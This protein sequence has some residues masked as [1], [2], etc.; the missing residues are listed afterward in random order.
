MIEKP[1]YII[2]HYRNLITFYSFGFIIPKQILLNFFKY[3]SLEKFYQYE[4]MMTY[5]FPNK[6]ESDMSI[7]ELRDFERNNIA[8]IK[9]DLKENKQNSNF[10]DIKKFI[11]VSIIHKVYL[12]SNDLIENILK[13]EFSNVI[14]MNKN[15]FE[16]N[17]SYSTSQSE[18][19]SNGKNKN[20]ISET[21]SDKTN[22]LDKDGVTKKQ[23]INFANFQNNICI[24]LVLIDFVIKNNL[25]E[26][27]FDKRLPASF[28]SYSRCDK[29]LKTFSAS[30]KVFSNDLDAQKLDLKNI[31]SISNSL[32]DDVKPKEV[33]VWASL[34]KVLF[35]MVPEFRVEEEEERYIDNKR[36]YN[37]NKQ[38][39]IDCGRYYKKL[40]EEFIEKEKRNYIEYYKDDSQKFISNID[41]DIFLKILGLIVTNYEDIDFESESIVTKIRET[42]SKLF[43][44]VCLL[45][46]DLLRY[47]KDVSIFVKKLNENFF[48][49]D[50]LHVLMNIQCA[51]YAGLDRIPFKIKEGRNFEYKW[52]S[53]L[54]K[55]I[56]TKKKVLKGNNVSS[57]QKINDWITDFD[58]IAIDTK[59]LKIDDQRYEIINE[60]I[61]SVKNDDGTYLITIPFKNDYDFIF[62]KVIIV[63]G[64]LGLEELVKYHM[65]IHKDEFIEHLKNFKPLGGFEKW[66]I[67][68]HNKTN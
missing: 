40:L 7:I 5:K 49:N 10:I 11:P 64:K 30:I 14:N 22:S 52:N 55:N 58:N 60:E 25:Y 62:E 17:P 13:M 4:M 59:Y 2:T 56:L 18:L 27:T 28:K 3:Y 37:F 51:L 9:N 44:E 16:I 19:F 67:K 61:E 29:S 15:I 53:I 24:H 46:H 12:S 20:N 38:N 50:P 39:L 54:S 21:K 45:I 31:L 47:G 33:M 8:V 6:L 36:V 66:V 48:K 65:E 41:E 43:I 32:G 42:E 34:T 57:W 23:S 63:D 35:N 1:L 26:K 68:N